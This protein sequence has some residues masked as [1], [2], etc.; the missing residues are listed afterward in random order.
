MDRLRAL[1]YAAGRGDTAGAGRPDPK[2][3]IATAVRLAQVT[4]G[5]LRGAALERALR[6]ILADDPRNP[7]A[8]VRLGY[9]LLEAGRCDEAVAA[10][11]AAIDEGLPSADAHLGRAACEAGRHDV[12]AAERTLTAAERVEPDNPAVSANLGL[13]LSDGGHPA[14]AIPWLQRSVTL[15]PDLHQARFGLALA[16]A[17]AHRP[18]EAAREAHELLR[19]L[20]TD[21]PQRPEV[22]R[23]L[24]EL[25]R[26]GAR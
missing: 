22:E 19:R 9:L 10:F 17:R 12:A 1:G 3:R 16:L 8:H 25:G 11:T 4:S 5:E 2:D 21:A 18:T 15:D 14:E 20:P 13:L 6:G 24:A 23:L 7:Q 26:L